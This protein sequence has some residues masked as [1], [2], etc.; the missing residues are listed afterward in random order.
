MCRPIASLAT[1][2]LDQAPAETGY[3]RVIE[4]IIAT[5]KIVPPG[6]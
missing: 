4:G 1:A 2:R 3:D 5:F 6:G